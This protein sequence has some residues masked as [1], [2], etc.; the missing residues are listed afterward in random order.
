MSNLQKEHD[1]VFEQLKQFIFEIIGADIAEE[2]SITRD[3]IL[4]RDLEMD[5]I[6]IVSFAE[7]VK[8][9]YSDVDFMS[10]LTSLELDKLINLSLNDISSFILK[11]NA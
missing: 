9:E 6:E 2:L 3:S 1:L 8:T 11:S 5:S 10:W 7:K 4:T